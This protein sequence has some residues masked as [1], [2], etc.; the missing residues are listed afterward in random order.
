MWQ[1]WQRGCCRTDLTVSNA[2]S[3]LSGEAGDYAIALCANHALTVS[4]AAKTARVG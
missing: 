2:G 4:A 3:A 1:F